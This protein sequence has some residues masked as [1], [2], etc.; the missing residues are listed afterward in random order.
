MQKQKCVEDEQHLLMHSEGHMSYY[1]RALSSLS[2]LVLIP[3]E[4]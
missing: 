3:F 2:Q 1:T 4:S